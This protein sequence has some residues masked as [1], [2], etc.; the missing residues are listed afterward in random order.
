MRPCDKAANCLHLCMDPER[1]ADHKWVREKII[2]SDG[3]SAFTALL[4]NGTVAEME[5][6]VWCLAHV[7]YEENQKDVMLAGGVTSSTHTVHATTH[8]ARTRV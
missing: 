2:A 1:N 8:F 7:A 3:L 5:A 6:A 4:K